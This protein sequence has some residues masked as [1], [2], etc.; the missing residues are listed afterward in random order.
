MDNESGILEMTGYLS[1]CTRFSYAKELLYQPSGREGGKEQ[2][3][4]D[5]VIGFTFSTGNNDSVR[6]NPTL[7][8]GTMV[9]NVGGY[10]GLLLGY[11]VMDALD[12]IEVM[13]SLLEARVRRRIVCAP[14]PP[15]YGGCV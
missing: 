13:A 15:M 8:L 7:P 12:W 3:E 5:F 6:Q 1:Q 10:L 2:D 14:H 11:S 4:G 9:G